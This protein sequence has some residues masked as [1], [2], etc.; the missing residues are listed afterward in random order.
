MLVRQNVLVIPPVSGPA[1]FFACLYTGNNGGKIWVSELEL[2]NIEQW[3]ITLQLLQTGNGDIGGDS[4]VQEVTVTIK[5]RVTK[6]TK[7][8]VVTVILKH[9]YTSEKMHIRLLRPTAQHSSYNTPQTKCQ[10]GC[11]TFLT[12]C[13]RYWIFWDSICFLA[14][15]RY[16]CHLWVIYELEF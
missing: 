1:M 12:G 4:W 16:T 11:P 2:I 14:V 3:S 13:G 15:K 5:M 10:Q 8:R 7:G 9:S 6:A